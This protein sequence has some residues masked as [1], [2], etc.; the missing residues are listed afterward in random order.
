MY[1]SVTIG[2]W[3]GGEKNFMV[4]R[5]IGCVDWF[6][7]SDGKMFG[8]IKYHDGNGLEKSIFFHKNYIIEKDRKYLG[9]FS[10]NM[11]VTFE[12]KNSEKQKDKFEA[13]QVSVLDSETN[14]QF[15]YEKFFEYFKNNK[16]DTIYQQLCKKLKV[17][18]AK[19]QDSLTALDEKILEMLQIKI[20]DDLLKIFSKYIDQN[21]KLLATLILCCVSAFKKDNTQLFKIISLL[22]QYFDKADV[23][24]SF[25]VHLLDTSNFLDC[26]KDKGIFAKIQHD[27]IAYNLIDLLDNIKQNLDLDIDT[28]IEWWLDDVITDFDFGLYCSRIALLSV[29]YQQLFIKKL[30][31]YKN[32]GF[33]NLDLHHILSINVSDYSTKVVFEILRQL[34]TQQNFNQKSIQADLLRI[35]SE[36][37]LINHVDDVLNLQG[38]FNFCQGRVKEHNCDVN[39]SFQPYKQTSLPLGKIIDGKQYYYVREKVETVSGLDNDKPII[40]DGQ[41]SMNKGQFNLS[42]GQACFWWCRNKQCFY[43]SRKY[44]SHVHDWKNYTLIDFLGI[45]NMVNDNTDNQIG[46]FYGAINHVNKF[47]SRLNCRGCKRL[48]K[49]N[50]NSNYTFYRV[51]NLSCDNPNCTQPD[52]DVYL[53]H[54]ANGRCDGIIDSRVSQR[55]NNGFV[56]CEQCFACCDNQRL[57]NRNS[58]RAINGLEKVVWEIVHRGE[59][60][61]CPQCANPMQFRDIHQRRQACATMINH[62]QNLYNDGT[63]TENNIV[64]NMGTYQ[65][66]QQQ[67]FVL[68][69]RHLN[70]G[71]FINWLYD[72]QE[73]GFHITDF[74]DDLSKLHY[75][76]ITPLQHELQQTK[77]FHCRNCNTTYNYTNDTIKSQAVIYWHSALFN[78]IG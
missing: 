59:V 69:Q 44:A 9:K 40:C 74:P 23:Y 19:Q 8:F 29:K 16:K 6:G 12:I 42:N 10:E 3:I 1:K 11:V 72:L 35:I 4:Q 76:V 34:S 28:K 55:C 70:N 67:W 58:N 32:Q 48:L 65:N 30:F 18:I 27:L 22:K 14:L 7:T 73:L 71:D 13:S 25:I 60:I 21:S 45:L 26:V 5:F 64:G 77:V 61:L 50:G 39:N 53:S 49:P 75:R 51:R 24:Q 47:L 43:I 78:Q 17:E 52:T 37:N 36:S 63:P 33:L 38:Y 54:C 57:E 20:N 68:Y 15:L 41:I 31:Y 56:I 62:L 2:V 46:L 66:T